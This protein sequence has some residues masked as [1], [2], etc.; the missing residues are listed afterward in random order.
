MA[1]VY[2]DEDADIALLKDK[3]IA[4]IGYGAQGHAQAQNLRDSGLDVIVAELRDSPNYKRA[5]DDGFKPVS[6]QEASKVADWIQILTPDHIQSDIWKNEIRPYIKSGVIIG[7]SHGFN[8]RFGQI[9]PPEDVDVVMIAP[10]GPGTL[11]RRMFLDGKGIPSLIAV[12]RDYSGKAKDYALAYAK[13]IG[14][15]RVGVIE[16]TFAEETETDLFGEQVIL[17]GGVVE[18]IKSSF[19]TLVDAGYQ[20]EVAYFECLH[21]LKLITDLIYE[22]GIMYM[23]RAISDTA[24]YGEYTRGRRVIG[25][26]VKKEMKKILQEVKSGEFAKEWIL[27]NQAGRPRFYSYRRELANHLIEQVGKKLRAMMPW[28]KK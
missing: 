6:T 20:P 3:K 10:K 23:N 7:F 21:E 11:L 19:E 25:E 17:C 18:L 15:T 22:G 27:E 9:I 13:A 16:T 26:R 24:E 12:E 2:Y 8:I 28:L 5:I 14:S 1:R 4:I